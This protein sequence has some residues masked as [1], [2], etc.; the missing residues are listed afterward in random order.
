MK[1]KREWN[2]IGRRTIFEIFQLSLTYL[3]PLL[4][5]LVEE[6]QVPV[7][8]LFLQNTQTVVRKFG[9][10]MNSERMVRGKLMLFCSLKTHPIIVT[11]SLCLEQGVKQGGARST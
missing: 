9:V 2:R 3:C 4:V 11:N 7:F 5:A 1:E 8:K 6:F 10:L